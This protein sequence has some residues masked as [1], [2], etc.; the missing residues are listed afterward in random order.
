MTGPGKISI[1]NVQFSS[2]DVQ[3]Y[4]VNFNENEKVNS[5][6]LKNGT[7]LNFK[8]Q[9][10]KGLQSVRCGK[11]NESGEPYEMSMFMGIK[12]LSIE[13][14]ERKD[15]YHLYHC[16]DYN[17]DTRGGGKDKI[18]LIDSTRGKVRADENDIV[19]NGS[20]QRYNDNPTEY[21]KMDE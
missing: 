8:D 14:S 17:V 13:G 19:E 7:K 3:Y 9:D 6:L 20:L 2:K 21:I 11:L 16:D 18:N 4:T 5:V 10:P 12:G 1:G 15:S